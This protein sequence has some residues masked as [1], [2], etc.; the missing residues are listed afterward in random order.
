[1]SGTK[2]SLLVALFA[3]VG[4]AN[5]GPDT[6][7]DGLTDDE[8]AEL[9][10]DPEKADSDDDGLSDG[11]EVELGTD[12]LDEDSDSDGVSDG[13]EVEVG[14][15][16]LDGTIDGSCDITLTLDSLQDAVE[17]ASWT[18]NGA[19]LSLES[20]NGNFSGVGS[21]ETGCI[22]LAPARLR[23][24]LTGLDCGPYTAEID[25]E[26]YCQAGCTLAYGTSQDGGTSIDANQTTGA[27]ETLK[28]NSGLNTTVWQSPLAEITV[29]GLEGFVCEIRLQ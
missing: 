26:D 22:G 19:N 24:D 3:G 12:P 2:L 29:E 28:L 13:D 9:G 18:E 14:T 4:C 27:L 10:T 23:V 17:G 5:A 1:M 8:E 16:P 15:D 21:T 7:G 11:Y 25:I 20:V 6:D